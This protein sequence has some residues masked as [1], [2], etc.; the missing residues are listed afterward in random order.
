[1][2]KWDDISFVLRSANRKKVFESLK[3]PKIPT[4]IAKGLGLNL[5][6]ISNILIELLDR[7]L[8]ECLTPNEKRH[9][10]YRISLKGKKLVGELTNLKSA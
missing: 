1:M 8:I 7:R 9:K 4:Q 5:G 3:E 2:A 10:F 6:Y